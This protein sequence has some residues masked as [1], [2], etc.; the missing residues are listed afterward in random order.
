VKLLLVRHG[1]SQWNIEGRYQGWQDPPLS[2]LGRRQAAAVAARLADGVQRPAAV[3]SSPL[4]RASDTAAAIAEAC[5]VPLTLDTRLREICHG[6]WEGLLR[7]EVERRWPE[8]LALW[9]RDP[10]AV[11]FPGGETL[12]DVHARWHDFLTGAPELG[13]PLVVVTHDVI[14]RL[15]CLEGSQRTM[16]DFFSLKGDNGGISEFTFVH[17]RLRLVRFND[18]RH[19]ENGLKADLGRQAL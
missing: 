19:L 8:L 9:R 5:G 12:E 3:V 1:E 11:R 15:A 10:A 7:A 17:G 16:G 6:E 2:A 18:S 13:S 14:V 4:Q